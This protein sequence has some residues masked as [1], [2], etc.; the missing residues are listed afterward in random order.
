MGFDGVLVREVQSDP[1]FHSRRAVC[2]LPHGASRDCLRRRKG[3]PN[4][5]VPSSNRFSPRLGLAYSPGAKDG[6]L[7]RV[8]GGPG[9]MSI[10]AGYGIYYSVI[11]GNTMAVDSLN[12]RM[13]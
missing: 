11:E 12:R 3:V 13:A 5:L 9:N 1:D 6:W 7:S 10:R 2:S 8:T 4:T